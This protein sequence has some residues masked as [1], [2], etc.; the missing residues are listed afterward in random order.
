MDARIL[1]YYSRKDIQKELVDIAKNMDDVKQGWD[2]LLDV[3]TKFLSYSKICAKLLID[4]LEFYDIKGYC[5]KFS[6]G[7]GMHLIIPFES[8]P[9]YIN[10]K[11]TR[12]L[13]PEATKIVAGYL[14]NMIR[15]ALRKELLK[16]SSVNDL[17]EASGKEEKKVVNNNVLDPFC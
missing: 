11:E 15:D 14:K 2:L 5:I 10:K 13:F 16:I 6:G 12:L 3:D 9:A 7:S 4:A 8:F 1:K 17:V